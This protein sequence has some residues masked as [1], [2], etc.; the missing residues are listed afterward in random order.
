MQKLS[1]ALQF[2]L[3]VKRNITGLGLLR[4][5]NYFMVSVFGW[6]I[7]L[8]YSSMFQMYYSSMGWPDPNTRESCES[9]EKRAKH[10]PKASDIVRFS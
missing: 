5:Y 10:E 9:Y 4:I 6:P 2:N 8:Y 7:E 3:S 1:A